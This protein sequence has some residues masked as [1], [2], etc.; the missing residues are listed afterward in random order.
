[1]LDTM[2]S[3]SWPAAVSASPVARSRCGVA[4]DV[5]NSRRRS[6]RPA[7]GSGDDLVTSEDQRQSGVHLKVP[8]RLFSFT[9]L[10]YHGLKKNHA[11]LCAGF[12]LDNLNRSRKRPNEDQSTAGPQGAQCARRR[13]R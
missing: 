1:M 2:V 3:C 10:G 13:P 5:K 9:K 11:W 4:Q 7:P 6:L 8:K 12:A